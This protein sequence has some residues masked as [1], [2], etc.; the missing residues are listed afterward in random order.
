MKIN[1]ISCKV[2]FTDLNG[3]PT[4]PHGAQDELAKLAVIS[5]VLSITSKYLD[6]D[7]TFIVDAPASRFDS[8]IFKPYF[9]TTAKNFKQSIVVLKDIH[10]SLD[11]YQNNK[12]I[13]NLILLN[14]N[15]T[16]KEEA[17][18]TNSFTQITQL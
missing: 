9:E 1:L 2:Q 10:D 13:S 14:K 5:A 12:A 18:M 17:S 8:T 4:I 15:T 11:E 7:Y 3:E 6:Q 16:G